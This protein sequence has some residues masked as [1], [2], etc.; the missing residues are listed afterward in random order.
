MFS[1]PNIGATVWVFFMNG[2]QNLPVYW[3]VSNSGQS[4]GAQYMDVASGLDPKAG[5]NPSVVHKIN[6]GHC[7][8]MI[9]ESGTVDV[10]VS[11]G[12]DGDEKAASKLF[13]KDDGTIEISSTKS[14]KIDAP[15]VKINGKEQLDIAAG[16]ASITADRITVNAGQSMTLYTAN[17]EKTVANPLGEIPGQ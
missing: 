4:C 5:E 3:A 7:Q 16:S 14:I 2:D 17:F 9:Y 6:C 12:K 1:Y 13:L 10:Q 8:I 11:N 15:S